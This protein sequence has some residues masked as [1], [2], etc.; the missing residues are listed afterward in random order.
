MPPLLNTVT[1]VLI[2]NLVMAFMSPRLS[3]CDGSTGP[4]TTKTTHSLQRCRVDGAFAL[5]LPGGL[6]TDRLWQGGVARCN[7]SSQT[8]LRCCGDRFSGIHESTSVY[9]SAQCQT[10]C[11]QSLTCIIE[12]LWRLFWMHLCAHI[13]HGQYAE[14]LPQEL[15]EKV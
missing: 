4:T 3:S 1:A 9:S 10:P 15:V 8:A 11:S 5:F 14:W 13:A 6:M 2:L 12:Q 7:A